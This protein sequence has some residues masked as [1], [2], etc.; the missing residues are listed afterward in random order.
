METLEPI[1]EA[2][3]DGNLERV[4][5]L[6]EVERVNLNQK[7]PT[8]KVIVNRPNFKR[9]DGWTPLMFA[10]FHSA[11]ISVVRY[12]VEHGACVHTKGYNYWNVLQMACCENTTPD[13]VHYLLEKG[14]DVHIISKSGCSLL[15]L[16]I[17]FK[18]SRIVQYLLTRTPIALE[19]KSICGYTAL[20][21]CTD[22]EMAELLLSHG[23]SPFQVHHSL[24]LSVHRARKTY[25]NRL[26]IRDLMSVKLIPSI[27]VASTI[28][29]L[30]TDLIRKLFTFLVSS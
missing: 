5:Y 8:A 13:V 14:M 24:L 7:L 18:C 19:I 17:Q 9:H 21:C 10:V 12:L 30:P 15:Y 26:C 11:N 16:A 27:G 1:Y 3:A 29:M 25:Y 23:A 28:H 20:A 4:K 6:V 2:C 22:D